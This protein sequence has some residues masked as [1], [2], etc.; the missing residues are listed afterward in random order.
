M[1]STAARS[2]PVFCGWR[3]CVLGRGSEEKAKEQAKWGAGVFVV[4]VRVL[5][6]G[7]GLCSELAPAAA[8]WRPRGRLGARRGAWQSKEGHSAMAKGGGEAPERRVG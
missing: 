6:E 2:S 3:R 4:P 8:R 5:V 1:G 7:S